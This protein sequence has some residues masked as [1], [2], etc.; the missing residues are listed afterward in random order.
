MEE[1]NFVLDTHV[2]VSIF[3]RNRIEDLID[4]VIEK[5]ITLVSTS[6][7]EKE[8]LHIIN[9]YEEV[10]QLL[11]GNADD[12][13]RQL[14]SM[15]ESFPSQKRFALLTDYK[16]NY[17]VDLAHQSRSI[18]VSDDATFKPLKLMKRPRVKV[19]SKQEFYK[20]LGW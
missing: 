19:I 3:H 6:E 1:N 14:T 20:I 7:Q 8:L 17:L 12:Y 10:R 4:A 9:D 18:L 16:D 15:T 5:G 13:A 2:W 11:R